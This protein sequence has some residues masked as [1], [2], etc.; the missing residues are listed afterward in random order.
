MA[1]NCSYNCPLCVS[2]ALP[3]MKGV[4]RHIGL[5]HSHEAGFR[6]VCGVGGCTRAHR[7]FTSYKKHMYV[8]HHDVLGLSTRVRSPDVEGLDSIMAPVNPEEEQEAYITQRDRSTALF[9]LK[10]REIHRVPQSS[11]CHLLG[12]ISTYIRHDHEQADTECGSSIERTG[13]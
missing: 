10:T 12:Y 9:I 7:N 6:V 13:N 5:V 4:I 1:C 8:K 11:L 3:H 2:F